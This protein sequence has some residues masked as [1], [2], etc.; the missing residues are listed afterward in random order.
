MI[1]SKPNVDP[2]GLYNQKQT[3]EALHLNRHTIARYHRDGLIKFRVRRCGK[4]LVTTG[5]EII[6]CWKSMYL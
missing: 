1:I 3:A 4:E 5:S 6:K 2:D